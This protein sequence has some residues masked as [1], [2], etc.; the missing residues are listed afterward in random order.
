MQHDGQNMR[1][2]M[3]LFEGEQKQSIHER[4]QLN[5][6]ANMVQIINLIGQA[7]H[8]APES[9]K[10]PLADAL[11]EYMST[12]K[13]SVRSMNPYMK[14]LIRELLEA[15]DATPDMEEIYW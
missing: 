2:Y 10:G 4:K 14:E 12:Y 9:A 1:Q 11:T 8:Q 15:T 3:N 6:S 5:E 13:H 7:V